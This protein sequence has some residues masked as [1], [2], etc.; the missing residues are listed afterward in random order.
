MED[1]VYSA[2]EGR[3]VR[4][5]V[6][7]TLYLAVDGTG[8]PGGEEF[9]RAIK[10]LYRASYAIHFRLK[11]TGVQRKIGSLEALWD[12]DGHW[13]AL[14][15]QPD[16]LTPGL[17]RELKLD[18]A[19]RLEHLH[20]GRCI[21]TMH[22]GPYGEEDRSVALLAAYADEHGFAF[23]GRHHEI[24]VSDPRRTPA[25]RLR[26]IIRHPVAPAASAARV[27]A[28]VASAI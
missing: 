8:V 18:R 7:G 1:E 15:A 9:Q 16:D 25:V 20:E 5:D 22:V 24:Y 19:V 12:L 21:Q 14:I 10:V 23:S 4:V 17:L 2:P 11:R 28:A 27:P 26:T 3:A 6:P 13:T